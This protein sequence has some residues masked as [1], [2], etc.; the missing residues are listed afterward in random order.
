[1]TAQPLEGGTY[2]KPDPDGMFW[3]MRKGRAK[4]TSDRGYR[5]ALSKSGRPVATAVLPMS[6]I[7]AD[8]KMIDMASEGL[9]GRLYLP[10]RGGRVPAVIAFGGSE[11]GP[12]TGFSNA[13]ALVN[14]GFAALGLAY[15]GTKGVPASLE[16]IPLEYFEKAIRALRAR[17]EIGDIAVMG[18]SRG[19]ELALLL[20]ATF[21]DIK[22]VVAQ[23]PSPARWS[24]FALPDE[25]EQFP[26]AWTYHGRAFSYATVGEKFGKK[27]LPDGRFV[28][29]NRPAFEKALANKAM[30]AA[31][32]TEIEKIN[33]PV[34]LLGA[35]DDQVWPSCTLSEMALARLKEKKHPFP[36]EMVCY[37][38]AGHGMCSPP[39]MPTQE[40]FSQNQS[41]RMLLDLGGTPEGNAAAQR[42]S[43][44]KTLQFLRAN[45]R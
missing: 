24:G 29:A 23:V 7:S 20:G 33:G 30:I 41:M 10:A 27:K 26:P 18:M 4:A 21:P 36:D 16:K 11:G 12:A 35:E 9:V 32:T 8:V 15:F 44:T 22:A 19:G 34:L 2:D 43:W 37:S 40:T 13:A 31:A 6:G 1:S 17:P 25:R 28:F 45:L 38:G 42:A 39:F 5:F 3:S 14:E